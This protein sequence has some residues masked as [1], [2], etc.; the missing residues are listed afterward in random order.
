[1]AALV[2]R[3]GGCGAT[4]S[5][6]RGLWA[7]WHAR[8]FGVVADRASVARCQRQGG[9]RS[10]CFVEGARAHLARVERDVVYGSES[11]VRNPSRAALACGLC[12]FTTSVAVE[13]QTQRVASTT[14]EL[15]YDAALDLSVT[16]LGGALWITSELLKRSLAPAEC[17]WCDRG[18]EGADTLNGV[19]SW[20]R[21]SLRWSRPQTANVVSNV[22]A[23]ALSPCS[24]WD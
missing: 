14:Y 16:A 7:R 21:S 18:P 5:A 19:D 17:H 15:R 6:R 20:F 24:E 9:R 23:F 12:L 3:R 8:P 2:E 4:L 10:R 11:L 13:A 22:T 1:M